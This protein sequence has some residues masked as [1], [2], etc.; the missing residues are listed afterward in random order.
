MKQNQHRLTAL[1]AL[2]FTVLLAAG[3]SSMGGMSPGG[4]AK[5]SGS[6]EVPPVMTA[7]SG[8]ASI[9]VAA[10]KSVTGT[11]TTTGIDSKAA[12]IHQAASGVNGPVIVGLTKNADGSFSVPAGAKL[13]DEQYASYQAGNMYVNVHSAAHPGGEIRVQLNSK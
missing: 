7:A 9:M 12:H 6:Q 4:S 1:A 11:V 5:L 8:N 13:T 2:T 3:C 10:D